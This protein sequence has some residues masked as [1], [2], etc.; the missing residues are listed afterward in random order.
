MSRQPSAISYQAKL[1]I[2]AAPLF[3]GR[4]HIRF[5]LM[6]DGMALG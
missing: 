3:S 2:H 1:L 4:E 6:A 5:F